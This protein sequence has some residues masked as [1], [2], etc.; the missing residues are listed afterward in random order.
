M[1]IGIVI[2][3]LGASQIGF[4]AINAINDLIAQK[5]QG[6][7]VLFFEQVTVP[8]LQ[9][10]CGTMCIN[11]LMSFKGILITTTLTNTDMTLARNSRSENKI[12]HY[13]WDL[14]WM[15]PRHNNYLEN[16]RIF[17]QVNKLVARSENHARALSNYCNRTIDLVSPQFNISEII[18]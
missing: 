3:H 18:K 7:I 12:I 6:D 14:E 11:E 8:I 10:Q 13:V 9:P 5:Y 2:P 16:F 15:R 17:N 1:N 4:Y